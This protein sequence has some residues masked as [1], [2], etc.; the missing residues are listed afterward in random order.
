MKINCLYGIN[1]AYLAQGY[2]IVIDVLRAFTTAAT[3][4]DKG[5]EK[6]ILVSD[7]EEAFALKEKNPSYL[8]VGEEG[9]HQISGF[10]FGNSPEVISK[11]NFLGKTLVLRSSSGTQGVVFARQAEKMFL[12]S[13]VVARATI[14]EIK[15]RKA[16]TVSILAM[17]APA[18]TEVSDEDLVCQEYMTGLLTN[19]S[20][21]QRQIRDRVYQSHAGKKALNPQITFISAEDLERA[22]QVDHFSF[23]MEVTQEQ[24]LFVARP[25]KQEF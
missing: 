2:V 22:V 18:E 24:G 7:P 20:M 13:L 1:Q 11:Q 23:Y 25:F 9:G 15:K 6:I 19:K 12:G 4:F 21:G 10:D 17:G 16:S 3:A 5:A 8:L 14:E